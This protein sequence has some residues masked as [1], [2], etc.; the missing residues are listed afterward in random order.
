M[1]A[2]AKAIIKG[3]ISLAL[4][5]SFTVAQHTRITIDVKCESQTQT[6]T[7][8]DLEITVTAPDGTPH[9][10]VVHAPNHSD[11]KM[12]TASL[13][14]KLNALFK[15]RGAPR[16]I[17]GETT[18]ESGKVSERT[19]EDCEAPPD[20]KFTGFVTK[21]NKPKDNGDPDFVPDNDHVQIYDGGTKLN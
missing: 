15:L 7:E 6:D 12:M 14:K 20:Y 2:L 18:N 16:F 3:L 17:Y 4:F 5:A 10:V 19:A 21:K 13:A 1:Q 9:T 8:W 11:A